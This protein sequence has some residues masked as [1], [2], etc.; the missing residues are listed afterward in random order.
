MRFLLTFALISSLLAASGC[1]RRKEIW[2]YTTLPKEVIEEMVE[3]LHVAVPEADVKWYQS[4]SENV[5]GRLS[6]EM[7]SG[8]VKADLVMTGDPVWYVEMK[9]KGK[10]LAYDS[11]AAKEV[12]AQLRDP[13]NTFVTVRLPVMVMGYNSALLK[14]G[15]LP[16]RWKDLASPRFDRKVSM[17]SPLDSASTFVALSMLSK[18]FGWEYFAELRKLGLVAEGTQSSVLTRIE[19]GERPIGILP[20]EMVVRAGRGKSLIKPIYPLDGTIVVPNPIAILKDT[21]HP[22]VA[23]KIYDWFFSP[24]AQSSIVR[25]GTYSPLPKTASPDGA[26]PWNELQMQVMKWTPEALAGLLS[27]RDRIKAKFSEVVLH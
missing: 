18:E 24:A 19:T 22:E 4:G 7:D 1:T 25:G 21:E 16:E 27:G 11:P 12:P 23:Q 6:S 15:E 26:R 5:A 13:D 14:P 10:L 9:Q 8:K 17:A 3:P 2:I 20:L